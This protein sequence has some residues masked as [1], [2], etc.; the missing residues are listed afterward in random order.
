M[1]SRIFLGALIALSVSIFACEKKKEAPAEPLTPEALV[2][3]GRSVYVANCLACHNADPS[4][5]GAVGPAI[6][7]SS[8][9]L[10][11]AKVL[12]GTY[13][14][15]HSPKRPTSVMTKFPQLKEQLPAVHAFL[16]Q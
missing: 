15:G 7:G 9:E 6:K 12:T 8:L 16:A 4:L 13:P 14:A 10:L 3:K 1:T 2:Q 11:E 5:E